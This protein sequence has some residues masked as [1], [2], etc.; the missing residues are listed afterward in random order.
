MD[1]MALSF[2]PLEIGCVAKVKVIGCL[3]LEDEEGL[4]PKILSVLIDDARFSG[5][6]DI[7][8]VHSHELKEIQE[9]FETYKRLEPH[10][11]TRVKGWENA[12]E[13]KELVAKAMKNY[14]KETTL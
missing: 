4:D 6:E 14:R 9:F 12:I 10:K 1:I 3:L 11:W 8:D 5:Y 2:E 7:S 13:A